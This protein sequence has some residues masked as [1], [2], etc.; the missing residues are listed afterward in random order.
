MKKIILLLLIS[1]GVNAQTGVTSLNNVPYSGATKSVNLGAQT[2][3]TTGP[4]YGNNIWYKNGNTVGTNTAYIGTNDN[5]SLYVK[6]NS[7]TVGKWDT[8]GILNIGST[9]VT[10]TTGHGRLRITGGGVSTDIGPYNGVPGYSALWLNNIQ[11]NA[12]NFTILSGGLTGNDMY[13]NTQ[14]DST[15]FTLNTGNNANGAMFMYGTKTSGTFSTFKFNQRSRTNITAG[16]N[17]PQ[18]AFDG[19][20]ADKKW[21]TGAINL[22]YQF[23]ITS[24]IY[25][26]NAASVL[27]NAYTQW[28][29]IPTQSTN[30][31]ITNKWGFGTSGS[32]HITQSLVLGSSA[33]TPSAT[34]DVT[35]T[36]SVS[37]TSTLSGALT[38]NKDV[39]YTATV[40]LT[41][42]QIKA[43]TSVVIVSAQGAGAYI[44][45]IQAGWFYTYGTAAFTNANLYL[46]N[47]GSPIAPFTSGSFLTST[48]NKNGMF[49]PFATTGNDCYVANADLILNANTTSAV[50]DGTC[51]VSVMYRVIRP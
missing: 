17:A 22:D 7:V 28:N 45:V 51:K 42:A 6:T 25:K 11:P 31:S 37:G 10:N 24:A 3:S 26:A 16:S 46:Q 33:H 47:A 49:I 20:L 1:L 5:R 18:F 27:T 38:L 30:M 9:V 2:F 34:L 23:Y 13:I 14:T 12:S 44:E 36:M 43:G 39:I 4:V 15:N 32:A 41:A 50:G 48:T 21:L 35:G 19:T 29:D 8:L 40:N